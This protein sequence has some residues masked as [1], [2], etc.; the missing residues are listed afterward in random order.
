MPVSTWSNQKDMLKQSFLQF[1]P[2][3][4]QFGLSIYA[5][6]SR[7]P[8]TV[9]RHHFPFAEVPVYQ[10]SQCHEMSLKFSS[11]K[12]GKCDDLFRNTKSSDKTYTYMT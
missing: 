7:I 10:Q 3:S 1:L 9:Y 6:H 4:H 12:S 5:W 2:A 8:Y 11:E